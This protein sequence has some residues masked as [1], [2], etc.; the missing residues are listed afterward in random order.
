M[1]IEIY[2]LICIV[3]VA[4]LYASV[5]H[6]GASGYLAIMSLFGLQPQM[7]RT[8]A[9][10]LNLFVSAI[11]FYQYNRK[12]FF[13]WK[14]FIPFALTS[15]PAAFLGGLITIAPGYYRIILGL[16]LLFAVFRMLF[17][18]KEKIT[19]RRKLPEYTGLLIGAVLGF[20]S[21]LIG[22]GGGIFLSPMLLLFHWADMKETAAVSALFIFVNSAA[23]ILGIWS[24]GLNLHPQILVWVIAAV[25]GG[26]LG[27]YYG[28]SKLPVNI[29]KYILSL[30]LAFASIKLLL[31]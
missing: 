31:F 22:V 12:G 1:Q 10:L 15:I 17:F 30:V 5:G 9:L 11:A 21:G 8:S 23:G 2:I 29:L 26:L 27:S 14:L 7:L 16:C 25:F 18:L 20:V 19:V 6:G 28:S 3:I 4:F 13:K 24:S